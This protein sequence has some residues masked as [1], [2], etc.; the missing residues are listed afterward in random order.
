MVKHWGIFKRE[1]FIGIWILVGLG[2]TLYLLGKIKF[3]HDS[4]N[5]NISNGRKMIAL[6]FG[7]FTL[8]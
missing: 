5:Q 6:L 4:P 3:A 1:I 7:L 8:Y 2:L